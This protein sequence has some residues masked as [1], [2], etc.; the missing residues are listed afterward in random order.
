MASQISVRSATM[1]PTKSLHQLKNVFNYYLGFNLRLLGTWFKTP[2]NDKFPLKRGTVPQ[3]ETIHHLNLL[4]INYQSI[5]KSQLMCR[6]SGETGPDKKSWGG[7]SLHLKL[8]HP[9]VQLR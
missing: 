1:S 5:S 9:K 8:I 7:G 2:P 6:L 3:W 4:V